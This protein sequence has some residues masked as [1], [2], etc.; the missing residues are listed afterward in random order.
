[1]GT[2]MTRLIMAMFWF[3]A[4]QVLLVGPLFFPSMPRYA[5]LSTDINVGW[6]A[7]V[8]GAYNLAWWIGMQPW[9]APRPRD[10]GVPP[11]PQPMEYHPEFDFDKPDDS[12]QNKK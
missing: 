4:A 2:R 6:A 5:I 12:I 7:V 10:G 8:L 11:R 1:M 9:T 3:A